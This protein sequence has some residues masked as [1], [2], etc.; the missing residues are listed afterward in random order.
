MRIALAA[1]LCLTAFGSAFG[2]SLL[3]WSWLEP[4]IPVRV[5]LGAS[6]VVLADGSISYDAVI[7]NALALWNEQM[8][9]LP[10]CLDSGRPW[11]GGRLR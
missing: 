11:H 3:G 6:D 2:Y 8:N 7:E 5:Q 1:A 9:G 4:T 10:V